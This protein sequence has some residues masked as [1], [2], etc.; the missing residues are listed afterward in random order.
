MTAGSAAISSPMNK[1][2]VSVSMMIAAKDHIWGALQTGYSAVL[3][4]Q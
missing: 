1:R 2:Q 4:T 3:K